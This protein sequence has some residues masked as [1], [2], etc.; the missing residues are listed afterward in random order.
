MFAASNS[1]L[2]QADLFRSWFF[3]NES[4]DILIDSQREENELLW[5]M[6]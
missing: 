6:V 1:D 3:L 2:K 4:L 5:L